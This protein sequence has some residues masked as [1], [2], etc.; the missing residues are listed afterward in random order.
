MF[1]NTNIDVGGALANMLFVL[2]IIL[3]FGL[4]CH[5]VAQK[6]ASQAPTMM[7]APC[8]LPTI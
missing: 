2:P 4:V 1:N 3:A 5:D 6:E 7:Q 8:P